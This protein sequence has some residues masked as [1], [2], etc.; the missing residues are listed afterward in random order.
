MSKIAIVTDSTAYLDEDTIERYNITVLPLSVN[1]GEETIEETELTPEAFYDKMRNAPDLPTT[2]QPALGHFIEKFEQLSEDH[3]AILSFHL[4]SGISGTYQTAVS[5]A[6]S[7][8]S[9]KVYPFDSEISCEPQAFYVKRAAEMAEHGDDIDQ[10]FANLTELK[11]TMRA[12]FIVDDLN[13]LHRGGRLSSASRL[14]GSALKI[15]PILAFENKVIVPYEKVRTYKK[16]LNRVLEM[17][18]ET[19][20]KG[21][22]MKACVIHANAPEEA[23]RI[24]ATLASK[25]DQIE[26]SISYFGPVIG[27]HLGEKSIGLTWYDYE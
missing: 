18:D 1:F 17:L 21:R 5:A 2:S 7:I 3:D 14:I 23:E 22:K 8:E 27:T 26:V 13:H 25:Y 20:K 11:Q 16:A 10:I 9:A 24:K 4:S 6:R 12:Y 15:K 19:A